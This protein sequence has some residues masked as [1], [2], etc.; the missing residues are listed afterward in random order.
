MQLIQNRR[1]FLATLSA[2]GA[3]GSLAPGASLADEGPPE[4]TTIRIGKLGGICLAPQYVAD[5]LLRA[6][7]F[8]DVRY[9]ESEGGIALLDKIA[10][11]EVDF[12]Q[13]YAA[14][15]VGAS[16][17][18][19]AAHG[20]GRRPSRLLRA[21]RARADP[22]HQRL[23]GQEGRRSPARPI[24]GTS[25]S[26]SWRR[27]SGSILTRTSTG[28]RIRRPTPMQLFV[29]GK[30]D[31]FLGFPP[32]PQELRARKIG[33]VLVNSAVDRPWSQ[34]FCCLLAGNRDLV[35]EHPVATKRVTRAVLKAA[36]L[37]AAEPA[38]WR[39]AWSRRGSR[40]ATTT[41]CRR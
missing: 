7:G 34:Y 35:R 2:A 1:D 28:S 29:D 13:M 17:C 11:G 25:S 14:I 20:G 31:A 38:R 19:P 4:T 18:R 37:C 8:T 41:P 30:I 9:V 10:R 27:R 6:E 26:P 33:H 40:R 5:E 23:E 39:S 24:S 15:L 21:V 22:S 32:E 16:G 36:D 3:A 12:T